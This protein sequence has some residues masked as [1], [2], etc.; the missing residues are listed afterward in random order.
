MG[1]GYGE[2]RPDH[3][4]YIRQLPC[5]VCGMRPVEAAHIRF[6]DAATGK[7]QAVGQKP[8]D[9]WTV[10]LCA[11]HHRDDNDA[12]HRMG[13]RRFWDRQRIN[14]LLLAELLFSVSPDI[15]RGESVTRQARRLACMSD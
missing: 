13:E 9:K 11:G 6:N 5:C 2:K 12:Q 4:R 10:P 7:R 14:P 8:D 15:E 3:L 1:V